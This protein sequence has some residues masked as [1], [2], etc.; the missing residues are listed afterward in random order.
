M[1]ALLRK[2]FWT[3]HPMLSANLVTFALALGFSIADALWHVPAGLWGLVLL[4]M[5]VI[6]QAAGTS[7][8][9]VD[10]KDDNIQFLQ[11]LPVRWW[12]VWVANWANELIALLVLVPLV[13]W[14]RVVHFVGPT[15]ME[16]YM[17]LR[18]LFFSSRWMLPLGLTSIA[19][20]AFS[21]SV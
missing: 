19:F 11:Y 2:N 6:S 14:Y 9:G 7:A 10:L 20:F 12:Q 5:V 13:C 3:W 4:F 1:W 16:R 8:L 17:P 21:Y 18:D 15:E